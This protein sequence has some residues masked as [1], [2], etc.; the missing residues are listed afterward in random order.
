MLPSKPSIPGLDVFPPLGP[1]VAIL[2]YTHMGRGGEMITQL[3]ATKKVRLA[4]KLRFVWISMGSS[5]RV[6]GSGVEVEA[7]MHCEV[8]RGTEGSLWKSFDPYGIANENIEHARPW[9]EA[10][11][12]GSP[13]SRTPKA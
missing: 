13:Y 12:I 6:D 11:R 9:K 10:A 7:S 8:S 5:C 2:S 4:S 3:A 1:L